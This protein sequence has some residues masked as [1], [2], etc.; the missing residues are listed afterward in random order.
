MATSYAEAARDE[1]KY[2]NKNDDCKIGNVKPIFLL[3]TDVFD[4]FDKALERRARSINT[5]NVDTNEED[6][7]EQP[8]EVRPP[9]R[10]LNDHSDSVVTLGDNIV[11]DDTPANKSRRWDALHCIQSQLAAVPLKD[12]QRNRNVMVLGTSD[13]V[14]ILDIAK[15][16]CEDVLYLKRS[17]LTSQFERYFTVVGS[18]N[19]LPLENHCLEESKSGALTSLKVHNSY[20]MA[21][22]KSKL[23]LDTSNVESE[24][25]G[26]TQRDSIVNVQ[27][28]SPVNV[29]PVQTKS[30]KIKRPQNMPILQMAIFA[31]PLSPTPAVSPTP[32]LSPGLSPTLYCHQLQVVDFQDMLVID[33][34]LD[35]MQI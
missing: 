34:Y 1:N 8:R 17:A 15:P 28:N 31:G 11:I 32:A 9:L 33:N 3:E 10:L 25:Q 20:E 6:G 22:M 2:K 26:E 23:A 24:D 12:K 4:D 21:V 35:L 16:I 27:A 18:F 13:K 19:N 14:A 5:S 7:V 29:Q 30:R